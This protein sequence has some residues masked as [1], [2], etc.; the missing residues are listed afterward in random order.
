MIKKVDVAVFDTI[1]KAAENKFESG[2][3]EF[4]LA[5]DGVGFVYDDNNKAFIP[6]AVLDEVNGLAKQIIAGAIKVPS[7]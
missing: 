4:G 7:E 2:V 5:E 1:K 6:Q 3:H